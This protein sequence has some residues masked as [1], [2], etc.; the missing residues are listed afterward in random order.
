ML[1][2]MEEHHPENDAND[3]ISVAYALAVD[4]F[5][6]IMTSGLT[7]H[8]L[9]QVH[10]GLTEIGLMLMPPPPSD[11]PPSNYRL[12]PPPPPP[13]SRFSTV[14]QT[15]ESCRTIQH[16]QDQRIQL[17]LAVITAFSFQLL[18]NLGKRGTLSW[19]SVLVFWQTKLVAAQ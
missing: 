3:A 8:E 16:W 19:M 7:E 1:I 14:F 17:F 9:Q 12:N 5:F 11:P 10:R 4:F 15:G 18:M 13:R 6:S 2:K